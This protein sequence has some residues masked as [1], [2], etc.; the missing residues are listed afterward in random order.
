MK[1]LNPTQ[2]HLLIPAILLLVFSMARPGLAQIPEEAS[3]IIDDVVVT[4]EKRKQ[5][6]KEVPVSIT[7]VDD[8][9]IQDRNVRDVKDIFNMAPNL[10]VSAQ[11]QNVTYVGCRGVSPSMINRRYPFVMYV[12]GV[13]FSSIFYMDIKDMQVI[14]YPS[15]YV[16]V[17]SNAGKAHSYGGELEVKFSTGPLCCYKFKAGHGAFPLGFLCLRQK[18][19]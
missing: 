7:V 16:M 18:S 15:A 4:A 9:E 17:A 5:M 19:V 14:E 13:P 12:D 10:S 6:L 11:N 3:Q 1:K 8:L 2:F